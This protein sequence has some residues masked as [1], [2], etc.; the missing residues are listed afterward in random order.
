[1]A[2]LYKD[3]KSWHISP[4][5][6]LYHISID[7]AVRSARY[8]DTL[9]AYYLDVVVNHGIVNRTSWD[10]THEGKPFNGSEWPGGGRLSIRR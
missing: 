7:D 5:P 4:F 8:P 9:P 1:M 6:S 3:N 2:L 10:A